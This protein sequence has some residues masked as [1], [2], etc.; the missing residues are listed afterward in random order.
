MCYCYIFDFSCNGLYECTIPEEITEV[1]QY[2]EA[3][4]GLNQNHIL[5]MCS[6]EKLELETI[7]PI[8]L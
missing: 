5:Y 1:G 7:E 3:H 4:Y 8:D 2:L 6:Q